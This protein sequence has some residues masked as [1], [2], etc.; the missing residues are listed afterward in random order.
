MK[1]HRRRFTDLDLTLL[2][3][4]YR[5]TTLEYNGLL[6][7]IRRLGP[8]GLIRLVRASDSIVSW[9]GDLHSAFFCL[10]GSLLGRP[11][12]VM[13][14]GY[15]V[16]RMPEIGYGLG[17][18]IKGRIYAYMAFHLSK[19]IIVNSMDSKET[20]VRNYRVPRKKV[21]VIY[22]A[23]D[24]FD[25]APECRYENKRPF[26]VITVGRVSW[27][28][29]RRKGIETFVRS[30]TFLPTADF[31][32]IGE[33]IDNSVEYLKKIASENVV[34]K[35]HVNDLELV[36]SYR[37]AKV[38]VQASYHEGFGCA[39]AEA[40]SF[41]C[42]PVVTRR[43]ALPEVVGETGYYVEYGN[44]EDLAGAIGL[45]MNDEKSAWLASERAR[46]LF[47]LNERQRRLFDVVE[48]VM[49]KS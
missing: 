23:T 47:T 16:V 37:Q 2:R 15:D 21:E 46:C 39:L 3:R 44:A 41:G 35:T 11:T 28:N 13:S 10:L 7:M 22:H 8:I 29:L 20:I 43:G 49:K 24:V 26:L 9:W 14:G 19:K 32:V 33:W 30:A 4:K 6:R 5:I 48:G 36:E 1:A 17:D 45:A 18:T 27:V 40:M 42:V 25:T 12:V 38:V 34:F 31:E